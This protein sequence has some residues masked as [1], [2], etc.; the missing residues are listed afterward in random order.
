MLE[1]FLK[2]LVQGLCKTFVEYRAIEVYL[3]EVYPIVVYLIEV[4]IVVL[5]RT[6]KD[7]IVDVV[8]VNSVMWAE[9]V[10]KG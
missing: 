10:G 2:E 9:G 5:S 3:I 1:E 6:K 7:V 4:Y 8:V